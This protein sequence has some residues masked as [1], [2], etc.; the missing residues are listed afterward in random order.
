MPGT[1]VCVC[2]CVCV[3]LSEC[4]RE[5]MLVYDILWNLN[6]SMK[7]HYF[8]LWFCFH[9]LKWSV[10]ALQYCFSF[11]ST[12]WIS[13]MSVYP[14][15]VSSFVLFCFVFSF[16][17]K[18]FAI[19]FAYCAFKFNFFQ[20]AFLDRIHNPLFFALCGPLLVCSPH[21]AACYLFICLSL[22]TLKVLEG[23]VTALLICV[24]C[25]NPYRYSKSILWLEM[26]YTNGKWIFSILPYE[27]KV[28]LISWRF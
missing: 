4:K 12:T 1:C 5:H 20:E 15:L 7:C 19:S 25:P 16:N 18:Y 17:L 2:V 13:S 27:G 21:H 24:P 26:N 6:L 28:G 11:Y 23:K 3:C 22:L 10:I 9:F 8:F 14:L